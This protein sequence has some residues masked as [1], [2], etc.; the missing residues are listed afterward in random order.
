MAFNLNMSMAALADTVAAWAPATLTGK[1]EQPATPAQAGVAYETKA[2]ELAAGMTEQN[3]S[4]QLSTISDPTLRLTALR[5]YVANQ[6]T[7]SPDLSQHFIKNQQAMMQ[8]YLQ[9]PE[10]SQALSP[11]DPA[12]AVKIQQQAPITAANMSGIVIGQKGSGQQVTLSDADIQELPY[13]VRQHLTLEDC[14]LYHPCFHPASTE[15]PHT[16]N[17]TFHDAEFIGL[18][19]G[20]HVMLDNGSYDGVKFSDIKGGTIEVGGHHSRTRVE[21]LDISGI[22]ANLV[23][24]GNCTVDGMKVDDKTNILN[25]QLG[26]HA[27]VMNADL[28]EATISMASKLD[29]TNWQNVTFNGTVLHGVDMHGAKLTNVNFNHADEK[30]LAGLNLHGATLNDVRINGQLLTP[31]L[32]QQFHIDTSGA[33]FHYSRAAQQEM[34]QARQPAP[35]PE[36]PKPIVPSAEARI[37]TPAV[38]A[39]DTTLSYTQFATAIQAALATGAGHY[40]AAATLKVKAEALAPTHEV[41]HHDDFSKAL[42]ASLPNAKPASPDQSFDRSAYNGGSRAAGK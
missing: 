8:A 29:H 12:Y 27:T 37:S 5:Q 15:L 22:S 31:E 17:A 20:Q 19:D 6:V 39:P 7:A 4:Q 10:I 40:E 23:V 25:F 42:P 30:T 36:A 34:Q 24:H 1:V 33:H 32:A 26:H 38:A 9:R 11:E 14:T 13:D 28:S 16:H 35:A 2:Q 3:L 18:A 21:N 41:S